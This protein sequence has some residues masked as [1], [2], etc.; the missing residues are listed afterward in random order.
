MWDTECA[1]GQAHVFAGAD[2]EAPCGPVRSGLPR[3]ARDPALT[4]APTPR[5][6]DFR[7]CFNFRRCAGRSRSGLRVDVAALDL[8]PAP[9]SGSSLRSRTGIITSTQRGRPQRRMGVRLARPTN[10]SLAATLR[11]RR[12]A[13]ADEA[14]EVS[15]RS[16][17]RRAGLGRSGAAHS[18]EYTTPVFPA[19]AVPA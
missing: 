14:P 3:R 5:K 7:N 15:I 12:P 19:P 4:R 2:P 1:D 11:D 6:R 10:T 16:L 8:H 18:T 17:P 13:R 9:R